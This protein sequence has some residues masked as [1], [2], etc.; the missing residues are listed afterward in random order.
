M[1]S[2]PPRRR[3]AP[4]ASSHGMVF[5]GG[6]QTSSSASKKIAAI[7]RAANHFDRLQLPKQWLVDEAADDAYTR[8]TRD[9]L[10][11]YNEYLA[12]RLPPPRAKP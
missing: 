2:L 9:L 6:G 4:G 1:T 10:Q 8:A 7:L 11:A 3:R 12:G 5:Y